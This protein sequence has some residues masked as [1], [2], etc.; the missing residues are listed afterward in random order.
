MLLRDDPAAEAI[1]SVVPIVAMGGMGKT[2]L[3]RLVYDDVEIDKHFNLKAW[4][5][6]SDQFDAMRVT[7]TI[8]HSVMTSQSSST[9]S[10]DFNQIQEKLREKLKGKKFLLVLDDMWNENYGDW[11]CLQSPFLSGSRGSKIIIT[12]KNRSVANMMGGEKNLHELK[13]LSDDECWSVFKKHAFG[14]S[15][16]DEQSTLALMGKEI[17]KKCGGLPLAARAL[18]GLLR[19]EQRQ[20][21]WNAVLNSKTWELNE[22]SII[23]A[24]R[25]SY[26]HLSPHLKRCF[27]YCAIFPKDYEFEKEELI[28]LW[29][30]EG[31]IQQSNDH[32]EKED[33]GDEY[34]L[35]LLSKS[36][37]QLSTS[38]TSRFVMHD[39]V[40]DLAK[41]V[42][43]ETCLHLGGKLE[44]D[45]QH[46]ISESI[47]HLSYIP[48]DY[49]TFKR[50]ERFHKRSQL[51]TFINLS[52]DELN[53]GGY[54]RNKVVKEL[55][56]GLEHLRV[57]S[58]SGYK[59][60]EIPDSFGKLKHLRYLDLSE[61]P[62][63]CLPD[64]IGNLFYLQTLRLSNCIHLSKLPISI[65]DLINLRHL[66][67]F[68]SNLVEMPSIIGKLKDLRL[69]S[70]FMVG[71]DNGLNIK[72]LRGM[73]NLRGELRLQKLENVVNI[74]DARDAGMKLK[75]K[76]KGLNIAWSTDGLDDDSEGKERNQM[77]EHVLHSLQPHSN[78]EKLNIL[79]YGGL[80]FPRWVSDASLLSKVVELSL[81]DC[82]KCTSLPCLGQL[83]LLKRLRFKRMDGVKKVGA[84]FYGETRVS[85]DKFFP[86][87]E[88]LSFKDLLKWEHWE[89]WPSVTESLFP[90]LHE[91]KIRDCPKLIK[92]LPTYLPDLTK[93]FVCQC[94]KLEFPLL[95]LPSLKELVLYECNGTVLRSGIAL[96][97][98]TELKMIQ[99]SG[100][101]KLHEGFVQS[102][103]GLQS[104]KISDCAELTWLW[105]D[106][107]D[108]G[109]GSEIQSLPSIKISHCHQLVSLGLGCNLRSLEIRGCN[110]LERLPNGWQKSLTGLEELEVKFCHKLV[111]FPEVG[112]PPNL[113]RLN[114][115]YCQ[116]LKCLPNGMMK[117]MM[118]NGSHNSN[119]CVLEDLSIDGCSAFICFP[120]GQ[121]PTTL[122]RLSVSYCENLKSIPEGIMH[123]HSNGAL[124]LLNFSH[125]RS[126]TSFPRGKFPSTLKE[127]K[128]CMCG[129]L[130]SIS[131]EMFHS[132][133]S[134]L[135]SLTVESCPSLKTLPDC[136]SELSNMYITACENLELRPHQFQNFTRLTS[137]EISHCEDINT[138]LYQWGLSRL[139]S[140]KSLSIKGIFPD[141]TSFSDDLHSALLPI[142]LTSLDLVAFP[143]LES[144]ASLSLQN[145]S[146]L[147]E[148][149]IS[150]CPKLLSILPRKKQLPP[151]LSRLSIVRCPLLKQRYSEEEGKDWPKVAHIPRVDIY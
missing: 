79:S 73:T 23:P 85:G 142:T 43:N 45:S 20:E 48:H 130:E 150:G 90:S 106:D 18:G 135:Q 102:L 36:F 32:E 22:S 67:V 108:D 40:H 138:S 46:P 17:V 96:T 140:L 131:A 1:V 38:D 144:I 111:S 77:D 53:F 72:L 49:N 44:N 132:T 122:K 4:V 118:G 97:S 94:P 47:R 127:L 95:R 5:C 126:L 137:L 21:R 91:L 35:E 64:S 14:D 50:F 56:P 62:I 16:I 119:L 145:L 86:S 59:I 6:V 121:L 103:R 100:L 87:L 15:N 80:A 11:C 148:L 151:T 74:E 76:L 78:L 60:S 71:E 55:I 129:Q 54:I 147:R 107:D 27:A 7:K 149:T 99:I 57:L 110:K 141:A 109:F 84:E 51:R 101:A 58:L 88:S 65:G 29:M 92:N 24:L 70:N 34:F 93:L 52:M 124:Q 75:H 128:I 13:N 133:N 68:G 98:L 82:K 105:D 30:A 28:L 42:G 117:T 33:V 116:G 81:V 25:L 10:L 143:N 63:Q 115:H 136:L 66:D 31:L 37:F 8:L 123:Q 89:D 9:D 114:L 41:F 12:T 61:T 139:P 69:L 125:C 120:E 2:T 26:N 19:H 134:S 83:P 3:A 146:S 39:I 104:L 112:F 113:R